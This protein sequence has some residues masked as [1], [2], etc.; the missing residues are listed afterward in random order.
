VFFA[1]WPTPHA[2]LAQPTESYMP[3][4]SSAT[5]SVDPG[6]VAGH[7]DLAASHEGC[8]DFST[9][10]HFTH[11]NCL[12]CPCAYGWVDALI[13]WREDGAD[14]RPLVLDLNSNA[15][16]LETDDVDFDSDGGLRAG[17]CS[18]ISGC[19]SVE[20]VYMGLFDQ[21]GWNEVELEDSLMLPGALGSGVVNNFFAADSVDADYKSELH[22]FEANL[23]HCGGCHGCSGDGHSIEW[24]GG[25][26]YLN[27]DEAFSLTSYDSAEGTSVYKVDAENDLYGG[28]VGARVRRC[29][30]PWSCETTAKAGVFANEMEQSQSPIIDYP[31]YL[32]R[33]R[34]GSD[35]T[36]VAFVGDLNFTVICQICELWGLRLGYNFIWLDGVALAPDQ[37]DFTNSPSSGRE[38]NDD[39]DLFLHGLNL[40]V[41]SRW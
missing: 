34:R 26:R 37:L 30:G 13:L 20:L 8:H 4:V 39:G 35:E 40:G 16:L 36:D 1:L 22:S 25:F 12:L 7:G 11:C 38:L 28:Q 24:L 29:S 2:A 18:R 31:S 6:L 21:A 10:P 14:D 41:E 3:S 19:W 32:F 23:I 15:V 17:Y 9:L 27:L 33:G 5:V